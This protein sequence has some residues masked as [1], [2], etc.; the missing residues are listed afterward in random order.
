MELPLASCPFRRL[1]LYLM[2]LFTWRPAHAETMADVGGQAPEGTERIT[3]WERN[4]ALEGIE[5]IV[6]VE[7]PS[8]PVEVTLEKH[9]YDVAWVDPM[10]GERTIRR[11]R[12][13]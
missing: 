2:A 11:R 8:G 10:T 1:Y 13:P 5:Y 12:C 3:D 7:K 6:Y 4:V 9:G